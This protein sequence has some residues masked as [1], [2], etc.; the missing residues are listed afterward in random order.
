MTYNPSFIPVGAHSMETYNGKYGVPCDCF[1]PFTKQ[2]LSK[3]TAI[4]LGAGVQWHEVYDAVQ[5]Q[6]RVLAG[7]SLAGESVGAAGGWLLGGGHGA[8]SPNYGLGNVM[9]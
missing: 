1:E 6:G 2:K 8:L 9:S 5:A 3:L 7:G 4:T